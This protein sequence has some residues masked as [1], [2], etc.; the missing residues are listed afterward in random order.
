MRK[1]VYSAFFSGA[2]LGML[3]ACERHPQSEELKV[4][5]A[6]EAPRLS[7]DHYLRT[8]EEVVAC[9]GEFLSEESSLRSTHGVER[10]VQEVIDLS[11]DSKLHRR[12]G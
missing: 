12:R 6:V 7:V 1:K 8:P 2:L 5:E 10:K 4:V 9:L 11:S 3:V